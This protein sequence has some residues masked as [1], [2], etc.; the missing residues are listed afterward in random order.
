[1]KSKN[2]YTVPC[3][4]VPMQY[5]PSFNFLRQIWLVLIQF[6]QITKFCFCNGTTATVEHTLV[7][8]EVSLV[9]TCTGSIKSMKLSCKLI[10]KC[11]KASSKVNPSQNNF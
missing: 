3:R 5:L 6:K 7:F 2:P 11:L 10:E 9:G 8:L 1:M 4:N